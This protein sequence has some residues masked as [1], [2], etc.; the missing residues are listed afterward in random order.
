MAETITEEELVSRFGTQ[1]QKEYFQEHG[2]LDG[3]Y[4]QKL[5]ARAEK[6]C[7]VRQ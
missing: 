7:N 4:K 6:H 1:N 3:G 2:K 5:L